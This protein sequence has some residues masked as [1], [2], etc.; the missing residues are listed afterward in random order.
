MVEVKR[1][2]GT[3]DFIV[4]E[5]MVKSGADV[6]TRDDLTLEAQAHLVFETMIRLARSEPMNQ[7]REKM[8]STYRYP[9]PLG[10]KGVVCM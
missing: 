1:Q 9:P 6:L 3:L 10:V 5:D 2:A 7:S 4:T 8:S